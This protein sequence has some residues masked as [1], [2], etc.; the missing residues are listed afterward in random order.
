MRKS[1]ESEI[2]RA[3]A[4]VREAENSKSEK[5]KETI[6]LH[7]GQLIALQKVSSWL[8]ISNVYVDGPIEIEREI[9]FDVSP[10]AL[11]ALGIISLTVIAVCVFLF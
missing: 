2:A 9:H 7:K 8:E 10:S 1:L 11:V 3:E 5:H 6:D 4:V